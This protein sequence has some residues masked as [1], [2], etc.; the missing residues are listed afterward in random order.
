M[1]ECDLCLLGRVNGRRLWFNRWRD[2]YPNLR[3]ERRAKA[4]ARYDGL[5]VPRTL[6]RRK[7][8]VY[9]RKERPF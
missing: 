2:G 9:W 1:L 8:A 6:F 7:W 4:R 5:H 3:V